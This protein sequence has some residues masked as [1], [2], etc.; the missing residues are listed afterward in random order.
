MLRVMLDV[1]D[2]IFPVGNEHI[3]VHEA[4][5]TA[6]LYGSRN[7]GAGLLHPW[8][9]GLW[10]HIF[11]KALVCMLPCSFSLLSVGMSL[12]L[13]RF[14]SSAYVQYPRLGKT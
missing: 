2:E 11:G 1:L 12:V 13:I 10:F 7:C 9:G 5:A 14:P 6:K 3:F 8:A 4:H